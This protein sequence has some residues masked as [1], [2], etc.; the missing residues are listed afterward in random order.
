[1]EKFGATSGTE[2]VETLPKSALK[3]VGTHPQETTPSRR[4]TE[5]WPNSLPRYAGLLDE[6][7]LHDR[8]GPGVWDHPAGRLRSTPTSR[9]GE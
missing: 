7:L 4:P 9:E 6:G 3:L 8:P 5:P 1:M 2:R